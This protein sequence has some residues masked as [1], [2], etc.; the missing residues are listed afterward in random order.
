MGLVMICCGMAVKR[1]GMLRSERVEDEG[2]DCDD[3][4]SDTDW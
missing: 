3:G 4:Y 1:I 2:T